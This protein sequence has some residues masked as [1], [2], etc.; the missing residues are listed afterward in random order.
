MAI[1]HVKY[2]SENRLGAGAAYKE[3][4]D[5]LEFYYVLS[6][7]FGDRACIHNSGS[8]G[9]VFAAVIGKPVTNNFHT[10]LGLICRANL[11]CILSPNWFISN[12]DIFPL[13]LVK[14]FFDTGQLTM[15][16]L[17]TLLVLSFFKSFTYAIN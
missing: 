5:V 12:N 1:Y 16:N 9:D 6:I 3:T 11:P 13:T 4:V 10:F 14:I 17:F 7:G 8:F 15:N 2:A